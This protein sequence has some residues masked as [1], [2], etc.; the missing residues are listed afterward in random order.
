MSE[1][2]L[3]VFLHG[4][5]EGRL[6][7]VAPVRDGTALARLLEEPAPVFEKLLNAHVDALLSGWSGGATLRPENIPATALWVGAALNNLAWSASRSDPSLLNVTLRLAR[8]LPL[9]GDTEAALAYHSLLRHLDPQALAEDWQ[10]VVTLLLERSPLTAAFLPRVV[11]KFDW[12]HLLAL[13]RYRAIQVAL[14]DHLLALP[15]EPAVCLE[16]GRLLEGLLEHGGPQLRPF[17]LAFYEADCAFRREVSQR[18]PYW[19]LFDQVRAARISSD[20]RVRRNA[21]RLLA[22]Y[23]PL[24]ALLADTATLRL[25]TRLDHLFLIQI[26]DLMR[27]SATQVSFRHIE[28]RTQR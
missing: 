4:L 1:R 23:R 28:R 11:E 10:P 22:R 2:A 19:P 24:A 20:A 18:Q 3:T 8:A 27:D 14:R 9:A 6:A 12:P 16:V 25:Y 13:L 26:G 21:N 17:V 5:L 15:L 7:P